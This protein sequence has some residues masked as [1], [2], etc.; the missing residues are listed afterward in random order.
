L[1][2]AETVVKSNFLCALGKLPH[3][4]VDADLPVVSYWLGPGV[5]VFIVLTSFF[6]FPKE[7]EILLRVTTWGS[8]LKKPGES[9]PL[10]ASSN[11]LKKILP[12]SSK[13]E[14][15]SSFDL[16]ESKEFRFN[17]GKEVTGMEVAGPGDL[18]LSSLSSLSYFH[19]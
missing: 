16:V 13:R 7:K 4:P 14:E 15:E 6:D 1:N 3:L 11:S 8:Y 12:L 10:L 9:L 18:S 2:L 17:F 19:L 5:T